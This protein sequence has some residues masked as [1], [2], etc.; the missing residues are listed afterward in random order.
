MLWWSFLVKS[1]IFYA[2]LKSSYEWTT[3]ALIGIWAEYSCDVTS[4]RHSSNSQPIPWICC[5]LLKAF[6]HENSFYLVFIALEIQVKI[7]VSSESSEL[8]TSFDS[9]D[10]KINF[11]AV[12]KWPAAG[13]VITKWPA[14]WCFS[15]ILRNGRDPSNSNYHMSINNRQVIRKTCI[16]I[17]GLTH[18]SESDNVVCDT[19]TGHGFQVTIWPAVMQ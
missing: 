1:L 16:D 14:I 12:S 11:I 5:D 7:T 19:A 4:R 13:Q 15:R 3:T 8:E 17:A 2:V 6:L 9:D 10:S 18:G